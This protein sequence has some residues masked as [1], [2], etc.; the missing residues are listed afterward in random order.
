MAGTV[1]QT[2]QLH[3]VGHWRRQDNVP[4]KLPAEA[5][6]VA[7]KNWRLPDEFVG[8]DVP[9]LLLGQLFVLR[10]NSVGQ[11]EVVPALVELEHIERGTPGMAC[12]LCMQEEAQPQSTRHTA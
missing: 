11:N 10:Y 8:V 3:E 4:T 5:K 9:P 6:L 1:V 2:I 7:R 12:Q